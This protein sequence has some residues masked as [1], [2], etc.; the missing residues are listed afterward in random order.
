ML[1]ILVSELFYDVVLE[2]LVSRFT[3]SE[4]ISAILIITQCITQSWLSMKDLLVK[5]T[6]SG[7]SL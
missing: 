2:D 5:L 4:F 1:E 3:L 7:L 6:C